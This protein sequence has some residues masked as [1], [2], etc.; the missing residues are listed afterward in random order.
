ML[1]LRYAILSVLLTACTGRQVSHAPHHNWPN[2][3]KGDPNYLG[4]VVR[5]AREVSCSELY[6]DKNNPY[7][8][9]YVFKDGSVRSV[10][11]SWKRDVEDDVWT[12]VGLAGITKDDMKD[13]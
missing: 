5:E 8:I 4:A 1:Y 2:L 7:E 3:Y 9:H 12:D 13:L 6:F 11:F 10:Q